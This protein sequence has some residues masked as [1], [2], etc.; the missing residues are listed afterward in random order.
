VLELESTHLTM[1]LDIWWETYW[2]V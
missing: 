2:I 1:E